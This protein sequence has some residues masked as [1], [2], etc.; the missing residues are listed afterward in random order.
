MFCGPI[1][2]LYYLIRKNELDVLN[3]PIALITEQ[4]LEHLDILKEIDINAIGD[5]IAMA[6]TLLEMKSAEALP[7]EELPPVTEI[8]DARDDLVKTLLAYKKICEQANALEQRSRKWQL[9]FPRL[10]S[11]LPEKEKNLAEEPIRPVELWDLVSAFGRILK[12]HSAS[13]QQKILYDDTPITAHIKRI[14][15]RLKLEG[16]ILFSQLFEPNSHR[17][18][19]IGIFLAVLELVRHEYAEAH[20]EN[21]F[22]EI[23][24]IYRESTKSFDLCSQQL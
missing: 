8:E 11:D 24:L 3:V 9:R 17:T 21:L 15:D 5:F 1:D 16:R 20:Q 2:L 14:Y 4:F 6:S 22:G 23:E 12:E 10:S 18:T 7:S 19:L 13:S